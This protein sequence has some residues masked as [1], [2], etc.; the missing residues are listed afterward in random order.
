LGPKSKISLTEA[1]KS[2]L[3]F[4]LKNFCL[5][6]L[7]PEE[8][9]P[10][11]LTEKR[12]KEPME[13]PLAHQ[14]A[15]ALQA[16]DPSQAAQA[17]QMVQTTRA[18]E[19]QTFHIIPAKMDQLLKTYRFRL[20]FHELVNAYDNFYPKFNRELVDFLDLSGIRKLEEVYQFKFNT[21]PEMK[22]EFQRWLKENWRFFYAFDMEGVYARMKLA[23]EQQIVPN[24]TDRVPFV[25]WIPAFGGILRA[26]MQF[27]KEKKWHKENRVAFYLDPNANQGPKKKKNNEDDDSEPDMNG[28]EELRIE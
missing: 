20:T 27:E 15:Q 25:N 4:C 11:Q 19:E 5:T 2:S 14:V 6:N 1:L 26:K 21:L 23:T 3:H 28:W 9:L 7:L 18:S 16:I 10:D 8:L 22:K 13:P 12:T 17:I 24:N